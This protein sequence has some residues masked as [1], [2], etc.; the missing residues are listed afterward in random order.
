RVEHELGDRMR[1]VDAV[2]RWLAEDPTS[3][4]AAGELERLAGGLSRW[5]EAAA[6]LA[7]VARHTKIPEAER[8]LDLRRGRVLLEELRDPDRAEEAYRRALEV[9]K[10]N[11]TA[12][13]ALDRIYRQTRELPKLADILWRR[14]EAEFEGGPKRDF[15]AEVGR[16]REQE[17]KDDPGA[18]VAWRQVLELSDG[19]PG[20]HE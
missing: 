6:R 2:G 15:Y 4:E 1:A 3:E 9:D 14:A 10:L 5:E 18:I 12:L 17:L 19:D 8:E 16:L 7:D 13:A 11:P 20:A